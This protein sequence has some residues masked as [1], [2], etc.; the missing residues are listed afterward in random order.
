[1]TL[2]LEPGQSRPTALEGSKK[3]KDYFSNETPQV[4][5]KDLGPQV[6]YKTLFFFE[7]L[8]PLIIY[9][10]FYTS[11]HRF[12]ASLV[13]QLAKSPTLSSSMP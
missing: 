12:T 7:Y 1:L 4:V 11:F 3:L 6:A 2:P 8:G 5:F 10:V 9:P 13:F